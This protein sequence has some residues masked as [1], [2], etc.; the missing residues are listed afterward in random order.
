MP[1]PLPLPLN[2]E[3]VRDRPDT[4]ESQA[5]AAPSTGP[6]MSFDKRHYIHR[7]G[8]LESWTQDSGLKG[9]TF[10]VGKRLAANRPLPWGHRN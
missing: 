9:W 6:E 5:R 10:D 7:T 1:E 3:E 2:H 8:S 4:A